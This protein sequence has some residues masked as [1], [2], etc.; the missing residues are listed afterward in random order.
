M[1]TVE[2]IAKAIC[3]YGTCKSCDEDCVDYRA[4]QRVMKV[5]EEDKENDHSSTGEREDS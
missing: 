4:A 5:I 3:K 2:K 1:I